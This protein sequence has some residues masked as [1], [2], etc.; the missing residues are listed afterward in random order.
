M[1]S[2]VF[3]SLRGVQ[4]V[5]RAGVRPTPVSQLAFESLERRAV[6]STFVVQNLADSGPGSLRETIAQANSQPGPDVIRFKSGLEGTI[7]LTSGELTISDPIRIQGPG[8]GRLAVSG[9]LQSRVFRVESAYGEVTLRG[10]TIAD[11]RAQ[12]QEDVGIKV[13][14]GGGILNLNGQLRLFEMTLRN[15]RAEDL[16]GDLPA[17]V[18]GGGAIANTEQA[19]LRALRCTFVSNSASGGARYAFGGAIAVVTD[20]QAFIRGSSFDNNFVSNGAE[21]FGGAVAAFGGSAAGFVNCNFINN[22][23]LASDEQNAFGGALAARPGT[24]ENSPSELFARFCEFSGNAAVAAAGATAGGGAIYNQ[25]SFLFLKESNLTANWASAGNVA[26][27][28]IQLQ[29]GWGIL[30]GAQLLSNQAI[31]VANDEGY[32]LARGGAIASTGGGMLS[33]ELTEVLLNEA[34]GAE[35]YGG[36]IFNGD[37]S[38]ESIAM[39]A[40]SQSQVNENRAV[41]TSSWPEAVAQGGGVFNGNRGEVDAPGAI[42]IATRTR[43]DQNNAWAEA[44]GS[45]IGGGVYNNG[46]FSVDRRLEK[47]L[48]DGLAANMASTSH[49]N[50]FGELTAL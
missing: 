4:T 28:A 27:G 12:V 1:F 23:A 42:A 26:G 37:V 45:G 11:G 15:N 13:V 21:N 3:K 33:L 25:E 22:K 16:G 2:K 38:S 36:G 41:A 46:E 9:N 5:R 18:V 20:S 34:R 30:S 43:I 35:A 17:D 6:L 49:A 32:S 8:E 40:L 24:V 50:V 29:R 48:L 19:V 44:G 14:R 7:A 10:F 31:G 47:R 39:L